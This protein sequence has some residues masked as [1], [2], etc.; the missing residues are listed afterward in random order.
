MKKRHLNPR[1]YSARVSKIILGKHFAWCK[2]EGRDITW[3]EAASNK[4]QAASDKPAT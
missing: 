2:K 3:Y 4:P 1:I